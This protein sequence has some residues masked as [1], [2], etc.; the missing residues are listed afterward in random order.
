MVR[1]SVLVVLSGLVLVGCAKSAS[2]AVTE[3]VDAT[4][5]TFLDAVAAP[6]D[7]TVDAADD[8]TLSSDASATK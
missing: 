8:V 3:A 6:D 4:V 7:V 5:E 2:T 1:K